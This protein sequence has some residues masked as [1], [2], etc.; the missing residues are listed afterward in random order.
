VRTPA[1]AT[2]A[3]TLLRT[4]P[5]RT[6]ARHILFGDRSFPLPAPQ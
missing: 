2:T 6:A 1:A 3:F 4:A 5:G